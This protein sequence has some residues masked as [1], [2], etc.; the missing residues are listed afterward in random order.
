MVSFS[1]V[2]TES[3][4]ILAIWTWERPSTRFKR[5]G[6]VLDVL[7]RKGCP[8]VRV[9]D[10]L[11]PEMVQCQILGGPE[12]QTMVGRTKRSIVQFDERILRDIFGDRAIA[13]DTMN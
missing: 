5:E 8:H 10:T 4:R 7:F 3:P 2:L 1:T 13:D 11:S 12:E 6:L 9:T